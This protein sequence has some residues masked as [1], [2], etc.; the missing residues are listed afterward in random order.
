M[1]PGNLYHGTLAENIQSIRNTGLLPRKGL[2]TAN[3]H[4]NAPEL[5]YAVDES[6]RGRLIAIITGQIAKTG[7]V[8][9]SD[10]YDF[11][12]FNNDLAR[13][14]AVVVITAAMFR[15][16]LSFSERGHP[17]GVE[18]GD[19]YSREPVGV[20]NI[21]EIIAGQEMIGWLKPHP[22]DFECRFREILR[23]GS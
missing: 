23:A 14:G 11:D 5:V 9:F 2:W 10:Q 6:R 3:F 1:P 19:W 4:V 15:S 7:L 8:R 12:H 20:E 17:E 18:P 13:Y 16:C 21:L 22:I